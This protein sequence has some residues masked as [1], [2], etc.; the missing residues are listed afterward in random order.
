[1]NIFKHLKTIFH[2]YLIV[3]EK[4]DPFNQPI[5]TLDHINKKVRFK[6]SAASNKWFVGFYFIYIFTV[7]NHL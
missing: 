7:K 5:N 3:P 1:M 6:R 2:P 4:E